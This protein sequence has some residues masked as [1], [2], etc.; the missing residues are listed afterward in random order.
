MGFCQGKITMEA[1]ADQ[2]AGAVGRVLVV[3]DYPMNRLKLARLLEQQGHT[4]AMAGDG[5]EAL[6]IMHDDAF[7]VVLLDIVMPE[8]DGYQVLQHMAGDGQLRDIPVIVISAVDDIDSV[9]KCIEMGAVDYLPKPF[10]PTVLRARLE[11]SLQRKKLRDL[12][13]SYLQQEMMLRQSEKLATLGR[14]SAGMAHELNN[15]A[16][17][18]KRGAAQLRQAVAQLQVANQRLDEATLLSNQRTSLLALDRLAQERAKEQSSV[19]NTLAQSDQEYDLELWLEER[20]IDNAW[21]LAPVLVSLGYNTETLAEVAAGFPGQQLPA[22]V[23]WLCTTYTVYSLLEE[24]AKGAER[25]AEIV[26][27]LKMYTFMDQAPV[28]AVDVNQ[29]LENTLAMLR[30]K[31]G[32][33][34]TVRREYAEDLPR[35]QAFGSELN[36]VWTNI[37]DNAIEAMGGQG[38]LSVRTGQTDDWLVIEIE[39][40]G[41]GIPEAIQPTIFDPFFTTKDP[42]AGT[43]LGLNISHHIIVDKHRGKIAVWSQP[44]STRF[45]IKLPK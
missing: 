17:A 21:E 31:L 43:G 28:Q 44:G 1:N 6:S 24:V 8:M 13:R 4:V 32:D 2:S 19:T 30:S 9:V 38:E 35:I 25:I 16:A 10:N 26:G 37:F 5:V 27:A 40:N 14:L 12:E 20:A 29:G 45:E 18:A 22:V 41:P 11:T 23:T 42:G 34:I 3:D 7:D 15:P 33:G 36:Q 39:D